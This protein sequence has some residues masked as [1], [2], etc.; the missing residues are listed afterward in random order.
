MAQPKRNSLVLMPANPTKYPG[1][2]KRTFAELHCDSDKSQEDEQQHPKKR[3]YATEDDHGNLATQ[4]QDTSRIDLSR[5]G[6]CA[7]AASPSPS[8]ENLSVEDADGAANNSGSDTLISHNPPTFCGLPLELRQKIWK[9]AAE[10]EDERIIEIR[11]SRVN[12]RYF[13]DLPIPPLLR[14]CHD[15]RIEALKIYELLLVPVLVSPGE[16]LE[17]SMAATIGEPALSKPHS[18]PIVTIFRT[19]FKSDKDMMY[20]GAFHFEN[21][22][23]PEPQPTKLNEFLYAL[24]AQR[25]MAQKIHWLAFTGEYAIEEDIADRIFNMTNLDEIYFVFDDPCCYYD[26]FGDR[27]GKLHRKML[28]L[29]PMERPKVP[30][31]PMYRHGAPVEP[32]LITIPGLGEVKAGMS[33]AELPGYPHFDKNFQLQQELD[34]AAQRHRQ[35]YHMYKEKDKKLVAVLKYNDLKPASVGQLG[36]RTDWRRLGTGA[37]TATRADKSDYVE[38]DCTSSDQEESDGPEESDGSCYSWEGYDC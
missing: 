8:T 10:G 9:I 22:D 3:C 7:R 14:T 16:S 34:I 29:K 25:A 28:G 31:V 27:V 26:R 6:P 20:F 12:Q 17:K 18:R 5:N 36:R 23:M 19:Y 37:C 2:P 24:N 11:W 32:P 13:I 4:E 30:I 33:I 35:H 38:S 21:D 15:S 1:S